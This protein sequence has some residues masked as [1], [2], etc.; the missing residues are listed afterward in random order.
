MKRLGFLAIGV[1]M[2]GLMLFGPGQALVPSPAAASSI[3]DFSVFGD[4]WVVIG[5]GSI[6][7]SGLVGSNGKD[8]IGS[9]S[10]YGVKMNGTSQVVE[11]VHSGTMSTVLTMSGQNDVAVGGNIFT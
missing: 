4:D 3:T 6:V 7:H 2:S 5:Y 11:D 8:S 10:T 9:P 1:L